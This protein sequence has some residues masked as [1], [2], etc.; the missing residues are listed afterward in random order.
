MEVCSHQVSNNE[1]R[2]NA[3][4]AEL[5]VFLIVGHSHKQPCNARMP[6]NLTVGY[7]HGKLDLA[8]LRQYTD[9]TVQYRDTPERQ[10]R[11]I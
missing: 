6:L 9:V 5:S 8:L 7:D 2:Q 11:N 10:G 3:F 4:V 1:P